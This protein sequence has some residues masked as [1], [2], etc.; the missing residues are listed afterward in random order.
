MVARP[1]SFRAEGLRERSGRRY[2]HGNPHAVLTGWNH[3][4]VQ[5]QALR[6]IL[7][8]DGDLAREAVLAQRMNRDGNAHAPAAID[9]GGRHAQ[10]EIGP[11]RADAQAVGVLAAALALRVADG[12]VVGSRGGEGGANEGIR[13]V[14]QQARSLVVEIVVERQLEALGVGELKDRI[15][16]RPEP[17]REHLRHDL[18]A[19]AALNAVNVPVARPVD[20]AVDDDRQ[21]D[22]LRVFQPYR[23]A[24]SR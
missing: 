14:G 24:L 19:R 1:S 9:G 17:A 15:E 13:L 3:S 11:R 16:R 22:A 6:G 4:S 7:E 12:D 21:L 20:A 23:W 18:L 2:R 5:R 8:S 10:I